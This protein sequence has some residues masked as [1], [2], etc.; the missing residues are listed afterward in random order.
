MTVE[1]AASSSRYWAC[2]DL[3]AWD[4]LPAREGY[5]AVV[6]SAVDENEAEFGSGPG[7]DDGCAGG[8]LCSQVELCADG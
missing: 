1:G 4:F 5:G 8:G 7:A 2:E 6:L 3:R